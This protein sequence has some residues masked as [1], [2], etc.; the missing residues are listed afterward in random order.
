MA[1]YKSIFRVA[2][3]AVFLL[4][5]STA[6]ASG[7]LEWILGQLTQGE[8]AAVVYAKS[9]AG[10]MVYVEGSQDVEGTGAEESAGAKSTKTSQGDLTFRLY[11][12]PSKGY[13]WRGWKKDP[14]DPANPATPL[15]ADNPYNITV[16]A[17][18]T[19]VSGNESNATEYYVYAYF[20]PIQYTIAFE[21]GDKGAGTM[22]PL[23]YDV[24]CSKT[25]PSPEFSVATG[26]EFNNWK[27]TYRD[28]SKDNNWSTTTTYNAGKSLNGMYGDVTLTA[29][30]K[31]MLYT[32]TY[33]TNGGKMAS[34]ASKTQSYN[35][36]NDVT[37]RSATKTGSTFHGWLV[38]STDGNWGLNSGYKGGTTASG[39]YG[40][41]TLTAQWNALPG[42]IIISVTGLADGESALFNVL[43]GSSVLYTVSVSSATP[44][45][46]ITGM[47][48]GDNYTVTPV[49][50]SL[51]SDITPEGSGTQ[52]LTYPNTTFNFTASAK[53]SVKKHA[54]ESRVNWKP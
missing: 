29:Q 51:T 27:V 14:A 10:G 22:D 34:S 35:Y 33:D 39:K 48:V 18:S 53:S 24:A 23:G 6:K 26:Y 30:W 31:A 54:E 12:Y 4:L 15:V 42:D 9:T 47:T 5:P 40:N 3:L 50:W 21:P 13:S 37:L 28:T 45:V 49:N 11:A 46:T 44:S 41:V 36:G 7:L 8:Y 17:S 2:L 32:I 20:S 38:T 52:S 1:E 43:K 25:L 19:A 16:Q